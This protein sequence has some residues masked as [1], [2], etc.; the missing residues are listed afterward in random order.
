[1]V[2]VDDVEA[3]SRW[4]Q[5]VLG[6]SSG[7]GGPEYEMLLDGDEL[8]A[9]IHH[10]ET[11]HHP[12]LGDRSEPSRGNGVLLW[13]ATGDFDD[14]VERVESSGAEVLEGPLFNTNAQQ[15]EIWLRGPEGYVVVVAGQRQD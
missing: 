1:M 8:V 11:D 13:F 12:H 5:R 2:V 9:Q 10:W 6:L 15:R 4:F 14:V 7:H 3:A